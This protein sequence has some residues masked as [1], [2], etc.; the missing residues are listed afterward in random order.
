MVSSAFGIAFVLGLF[1]T[2]EGENERLSSV[3]DSLK[4]LG[5]LELE[6]MVSRVV[7][8]ANPLVFGLGT[9]KVCTIG[10]REPEQITL[11][12]IEA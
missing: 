3:V 6:P 9:L 8:L 5:R 10:L 7:A 2:P 1:A 11:T 4:G 12:G